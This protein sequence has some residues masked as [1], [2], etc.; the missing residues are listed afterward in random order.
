MK[1]NLSNATT[2]YFIE[3]ASKN[4][5][6]FVCRLLSG[7]LIFSL[8]FQGYIPPAIAQQ[9]STTNDS[10]PKWIQLQPTSPLTTSGRY[11][12]GLV[13]NSA[14]N[15]M[16]MYSGYVQT[17]G[18]SND[19]W[20]LT[21]AN[22]LDAT[23]S[24][25]IQLLGSQDGSEFP[26]RRLFTTAAYDQINNKLIAFGGISS[27][28]LLFNDVWVLSNAD[29]TAGTPQWTQLNI[30]GDVPSPRR[31]LSP[32]RP[33]YD[34]TNNRLILFG[35]EVQGGPGWVELND[36]W[37]LTNANG[38]GGTS[39]WIKLNPVGTAPQIPTHADPSVSYDPGT[40]RLIVFFPMG[41]QLNEV[42]V[43]TNANGLGGTPEWTR[44]LTSSSPSPRVEEASIYDAVS[45]QAFGRLLVVL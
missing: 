25:W 24:K 11:G 28:N 1:I 36:V 19:V 41:P 32:N 38:M 15:R 33:A 14:S 44:I 13:Y 17:Q 16:I 9:N 37:V 20:V 35:G 4:K 27:T 26:P 6:R 29:G 43:L 39:S 7:L 30:T 34:S 8:V 3:V 18:S 42:W 40:N 10:I 22:G 23:P 12:E 31:N 45:K 2:D 5:F 21:N